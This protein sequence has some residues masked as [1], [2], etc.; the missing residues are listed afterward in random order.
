ME[1]P[2]Q[3]VKENKSARVERGAGD[4]SMVR[5]REEDRDE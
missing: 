5:I 2:R 4:V 1:S 3:R